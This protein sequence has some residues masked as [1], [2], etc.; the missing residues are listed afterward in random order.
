MAEESCRALVN[1]LIPAIRSLLPSMSMKWLTSLTNWE[2]WGHRPRTNNS[3][4]SSVRH[5]FNV[6][7][8][9]RTGNEVNRYFFSGSTRSRGPGRR[10]LRRLWVPFVRPL[11][12]LWGKFFRLV[13]KH[14]DYLFGA[15]G[16][17]C[18]CGVN[19]G[20]LLWHSPSSRGSIGTSNGLGVTPPPNRRLI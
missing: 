1:G 14:F 12:S 15:M 8:W 19:A 2:P 3:I 5:C 18:R 4:R 17:L 9:T 6:P 10:A 13:A 7:V 20:H 16:R 11:L